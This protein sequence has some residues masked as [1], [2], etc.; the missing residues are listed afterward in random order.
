MY[1][2]VLPNSEAEQ[3]IQDGMYVEP[4]TFNMHIDY[5]KNIF[6]IVHF[7]DIFSYIQNKSSLNKY[8]ICI[9]TFDDGW[10]DFYKF[11]YPILVAQKVPATVFL[12]T[13]YI[14]TENRFWTD[15]VADYFIKNNNNYLNI[16]EKISNNVLVNKLD[17]LKGPTKFK[18]EK[19]ISMLKSYKEE[20]I[21]NALTELKINSGI[22]ENFSERAF[23]NWE[24]VHKMAESS[25]I[26]F[27]SHTNN[28]RMLTY[29]DDNEI[30][31]E[32]ME[33]KDRLFSEGIV[34]KS[35]IPF[36]YPNG[37]FDNRVIKKVEEAGYH[38]AVTTDNGWNHPNSPRST[39]KRV[40][41]H[42]DISSTK[43]MF[44]CRIANLF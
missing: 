9:L 5:L 40:G 31:D 19:A 41:I 15:V 17:S 27:G 43:A 39:L 30:F 14:G 42:Q 2:R 6:S 44:G 24:E 38:V 35:F 29:L 33:S 21:L 1:H 23:L 7:S 18:I 13:R 3:G 26:T 22:E 37:N 12:P 20:E 4:E 32:L 28:H 34:N 16:N 8:P 25:L 11:A 36:C 10:Y